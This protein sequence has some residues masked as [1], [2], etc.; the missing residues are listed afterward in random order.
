MG[1]LS[2]EKFDSSVKTVNIKDGDYIYLFP[3][4]VTE[5]EN[6]KGEMF[7]QERIEKI[8]AYDGN[9]G[10]IISKSQKRL[11]FFAMALNKLTIFRW[12]K[13][14]TGLKRHSRSYQLTV[15]SCQGCRFI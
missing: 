9:S 8:V 10:S 7:T 3:D 2:H 14:N 12:L 1:V 11:I 13:L 5:A 15:I 4:G 6:K